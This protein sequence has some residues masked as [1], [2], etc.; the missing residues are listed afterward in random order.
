MG[1]SSFDLSQILPLQLFSLLIKPMH[2]KL[3]YLC[4]EEMLHIFA[5]QIKCSGIVA[6]ND[7]ILSLSFV[8]IN[9]LENHPILLL[10]PVLRLLNFSDLWRVSCLFGYI[11]GLFDC[12]MINTG[13]AESR[14]LGNIRGVCG[15]IYYCY[16]TEI[17]VNLEYF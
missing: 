7:Y 11:S 6:L 15:Y 2:L 3:Q 12:S 1:M 5:K 10:M 17:T 13:R 4:D 14:A 16:F 9:G 8:Y